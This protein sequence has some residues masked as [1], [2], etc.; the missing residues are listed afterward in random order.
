MGD[1]VEFRRRISSLRA[2]Q[3]IE[4]ALFEKQRQEEVK[5]ERWILRVLGLTWLIYTIMIF[6]HQAHSTELSRPSAL[7]AA[8]CSVESK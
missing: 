8:I 2:A 5:W 1:L 3:A 6:S 4:D 7:R